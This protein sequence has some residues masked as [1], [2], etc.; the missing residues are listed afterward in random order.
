MCSYKLVEVRFDMVYMLQA[1][2]EEFVHK[3][4]IRHWRH[5]TDLSTTNIWKGFLTWTAASGQDIIFS[6]ARD[7][8]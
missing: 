5:L 3:V 7:L 1:R 8:H 6:M 2:I 4:R